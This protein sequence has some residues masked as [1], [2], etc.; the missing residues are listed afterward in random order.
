MNQYS[1]YPKQFTDSG[2]QI[3]TDTCFV[4]MPFCEELNNTFMVIETTA[5]GLGI[6]C[7]RADNVSTTSEP[8]LTKI[9]T[10]ISHSYF[11]IVD[12]TNLNPNVF[13]ELGIAHVLRDAQKVLIIKEK[14]T[15]CPS[16]IKHLHYYEYRKN[17]LKHLKSIITSFFNENN[18]SSDLHAL[19]EFRDLI[20]KDKSIAHNFV[21]GLSDYLD[22]DITNLIFILNNQQSE[23]SQQ[24][25]ISTLSK[26]T[27]ALN[28][29]ETNDKFYELHSNLLLHILSKVFNC[30]DISSYIDGLISRDNYNIDKELIAKCCIAI[31][32]EKRYFEIAMKWINEYLEQISPAEFDITKYLI[33]IG[34]IKSDNIEIDNAMIVNLDSKN[35][36]L[37]EHSAKIIKER[38]TIAAIPKL[39]NLIKEDQN[40]YIVR[41]C[42]DALVNIKQYDSIIRAK[43]LMSKRKDF[44]QQNDFINKHLLDLNNCLSFLNDTAKL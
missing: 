30:V 29:L 9:C 3:I 37:V 18:V 34:L 35:K 31:L 20:P 28:K 13:Y 38:R 36:T 2:R 16:D 25:I 15:T 42:I 8:I 24:S 21:V 11:I 10:Q 14:E 39:L 26:I 19:L 7:T 12:I 17:D 41:S 22:N 1:I 23:I 40:P 27:F 33:E 5:N 6:K 43:E 32:D 44:V 4:I